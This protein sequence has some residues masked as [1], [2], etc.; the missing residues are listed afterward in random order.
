MTSKAAYV[1]SLPKSLTA[2]EVVAKAKAKGIKLSTAYVYVLRSKSG[3]KSN[4]KPGPKP[5]GGIEEQFLNVALDVG[6]GRAGE[7]LERVRSAAHQ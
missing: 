2:K 7:L 3:S 6:I 1:R 5:K 4:G